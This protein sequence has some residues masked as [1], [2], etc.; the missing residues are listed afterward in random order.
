MEAERLFETSVNFYQTAAYRVSEYSYL[1]SHHH[2]NIKSRSER[3]LIRTYSMKQSQ[4]SE[5]D[6]RLDGQ[7]SAYILWDPWDYYPAHRN[8]SLVI[9]LSQRC[10][11]HS[12]RPDFFGINFW[13]IQQHSTRGRFAVSLITRFLNVDNTLP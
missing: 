11:V 9:T 6:N 2:E 1:H 3:G 13:Q 12:L 4:S 7:G 8:P 5:V 10:P